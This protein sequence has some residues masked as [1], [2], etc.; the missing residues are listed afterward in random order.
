MGLYNGGELLLVGSVALRLAVC[1]LD[2]D[3]EGLVGEEV[4]EEFGGY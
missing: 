1:G 2:D 3:W 4:R